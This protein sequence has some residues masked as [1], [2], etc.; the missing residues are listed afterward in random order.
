[1]SENRHDDIFKKGLDQLSPSDFPYDP[2]A[3]DQL[4][5]RMDNQG[6]LLPPS[7]GVQTAVW[8]WL[9]GLFALLLLLSGWQW[10]DLSN[11]LKA[12]TLN[13]EHLRT[14]V[15]ALRNELATQE[16]IRRKANPSTLGTNALTTGH[17]IDTIVVERRIYLYREATDAIGDPSATAAHQSFSDAAPAFRRMPPHD[18]SA[19]LTP[20][21]TTYA[22]TPPLF[23]GDAITHRSSTAQPDAAA[24]SL[25]QK[26][27]PNAPPTQ[28]AASPSLD[29]ADNLSTLPIAALHTTDT[30]AH[31]VDTVSALSTQSRPWTQQVADR[32]RY[33]IAQGR[34]SVELLG[35]SYFDYG[36][37]RYTRR[38][39]N[40]GIGASRSIGTAFHLGTQVQW[41]YD[42]NYLDG[43]Y[44]LTD[45]GDDYFTAYPNLEANKNDP[46]DALNRVEGKLQSVTMALVAGYTPWAERALHPF[47]QVGAQWRIDLAQDLE[48][49]Y[50]RAPNYGSL[51]EVHESATSRRMA[52]AAM[53]V[54]GGLAWRAFD[55]W[56][57]RMSAIY[58][59]GLTDD[60]WEPVRVH[61][62]GAQLGI[63]HTW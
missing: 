42:D 45:V 38:E 32:T 22:P 46:A 53:Q 40:I 16:G 12:Q 20:L 62:L 51:Y 60:T 58:Q 28:N 24:D 4:A 19:V 10:Y 43:I 13:V 11:H 1:M 26:P 54:Q 23:S 15:L 7:N 44:N 30:T 9:T 14:E 18:T 6:L 52:L 41:S 2:S 55:D 5:E 59:H 49:Y 27:L 48:Y 31:G 17:I 63:L 8:R 25:A 34:W 47:V 37:S 50:L 33:Q 61:R 36:S 39:W 57:I 3:W 21:D 35:T 56:T 29:T